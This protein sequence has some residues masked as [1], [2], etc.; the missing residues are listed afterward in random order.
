MK[1]GKKRKQIRKDRL[2]K[3]WL[4]WLSDDAFDH[5]LKKIE[6]YDPEKYRNAMDKWQTHGRKALTDD[7]FQGVKP[8]IDAQ[9]AKEIF[10]TSLAEESAEFWSK[11]WGW[12]YPWQHT[13]DMRNTDS[14]KMDRLTYVAIL[15]TM[16]SIA[17][18]PHDFFERHPGIKPEIKDR[19]FSYRVDSLDCI[20]IN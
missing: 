10:L 7:E 16:K 11:G 17:E 15:R 18:D 5:N 1:F 2:W 4:Y 12:I 20:Q 14:K 6:N 13:I 3:H 8:L 9:K 19:F